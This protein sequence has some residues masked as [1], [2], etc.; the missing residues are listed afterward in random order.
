MQSEALEQKPRREEE[1][2]RPVIPKR[3]RAAVVEKFREP[4]QIREVPVPS[5]GPGQAL[6]QIMATNR[7]PHLFPA[8]KVQA[9]W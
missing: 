2:A 1:K 4:L 3:M 6:I 5:P 9:W 8:T 7:V